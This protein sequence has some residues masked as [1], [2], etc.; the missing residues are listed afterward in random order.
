MRLFFLAAALFLA[1]AA[2]VSAARPNETRRMLVTAYTSCDASI[3][4]VKKCD[5]ITASGK[6]ATWG[7]AGCGRGFTFG[8]VFEVPDLGFFACYDRGG[9]VTNEIL[10]I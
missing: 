10:D 4:R 9:G 2:T 1:L 8:T 7:V 6:Q 5:G 3:A